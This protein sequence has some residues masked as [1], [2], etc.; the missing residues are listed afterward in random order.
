MEIKYDDDDDDDGWHWLA[1]RLPTTNNIPFTSQ[2]YVFKL[3]RIVAL[4]ACEDGRVRVLQ[5]TVKHLCYTVT[6]SFRFRD[7]AI[8]SH[9]TVIKTFR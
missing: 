6:T 1:C 9:P 5:Y 2:S 7:T 3:I 8:F 4:K